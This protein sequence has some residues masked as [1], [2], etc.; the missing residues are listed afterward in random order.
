MNIKENENYMSEKRN[1]KHNM[2]KE[3]IYESQSHKK[4]TL[5]T[6]YNLNALK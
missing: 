2:Q 4:G 5:M 1:E 3:I 6:K